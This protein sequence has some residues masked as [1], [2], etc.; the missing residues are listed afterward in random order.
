[1]VRGGKTPTTNQRQYTYD[2]DDTVIYAEGKTE[3]AI[4]KVNTVLNRLGDCCEA[5]TITINVKMAEDLMFSN[6]KKPTDFIS[7]E[8]NI[9]NKLNDNV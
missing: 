7:L 4:D 9:D 8:V 2:A 1:M 3:E 6:R 5:N